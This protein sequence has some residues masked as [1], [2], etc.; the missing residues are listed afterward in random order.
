MHFLLPLAV[1]HRLVA[2]RAVVARWPAAERVAVVRRLAA[3]RVAAR[4]PL[5]GARQLP[6]V[7]RS[8]PAASRLGSECSRRCGRTQCS[9]TKRGGDRYEA[10]LKV[11]LEGSKKVKILMDYIYK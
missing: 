1:V 5:A 4:R 2:V 7:R 8:V 6:A 3:E 11:S 10:F 9:Q